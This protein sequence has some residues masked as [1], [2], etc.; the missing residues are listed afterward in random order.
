MDWPVEGSVPAAPRTPVISPGL[1]RSAI[2]SPNLPPLTHAVRPTEHQFDTLVLPWFCGR[3]CQRAF[4]KVGVLL[5][6]GLIDDRTHGHGGMTG[7]QFGQ[8]AGLLRVEV[9]DDH[10]GQPA[11]GRHMLKEVGEGRQAAGRG[12]DPHDR[13]ARARR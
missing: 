7:E 11:V 9:L 12:P 4:V 6:R 2:V 3:C 1:P 5:D 8:E 13:G 10:K